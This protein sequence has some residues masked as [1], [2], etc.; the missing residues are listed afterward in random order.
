MIIFGCS[1]VG[2]AKYLVQIANTFCSNAVCISNKPTNSIFKKMGIRIVDDISSYKDIKLVVTGTS[3][4]S[5]S[6]SVDKKLIYWAKNRN[7]P[8]VSIIEHWSWYRK[9][10]ETEKG[11]MLPDYIIVND[12]IANYSKRTNG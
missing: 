1:D 7:I 8:T 3:L 10:F 6:E 4:G 2:P 9:R 11:L 5:I 12:I